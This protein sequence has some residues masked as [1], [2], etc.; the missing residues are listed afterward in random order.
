M[1]VVKSQAFITHYIRVVTVSA[2]MSIT[3]T[4]ECHRVRYDLDQNLN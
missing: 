4:D 3:Q 1:A 2:E